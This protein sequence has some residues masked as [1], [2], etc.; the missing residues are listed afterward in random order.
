M[1]KFDKEQSNRLKWIREKLGLSSSYVYETCQIPRST[2]FDKEKGNSNWYVNNVLANF[3]NY[4]WQKKFV[5]NY[6]IYKKKEIKIITVNFIVYGRDFLQDYYD[7]QFL[8]LF[9]NFKT[10]EKDYLKRID[11]LKVQLMK[12]K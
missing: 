12:V 10:K 7:Q 11:D 5:E 1:Q 6:P 2:F 8:I 9:Q 3:Y 4:Q